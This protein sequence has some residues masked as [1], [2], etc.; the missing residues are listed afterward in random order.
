[1]LWDK[2]H[3]MP[4]FADLRCFDAVSNLHLNLNFTTP[5]DNGQLLE[6]V[7]FCYAAEGHPL[8]D[9][10]SFYTYQEVDN[11]LYIGWDNSFTD[12]TVVNMAINMALDKMWFLINKQPDH[13]K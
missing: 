1:M 9:A 12:E 10:S 8:S 6:W 5:R 11:V 4:R 13:W 7:K 3:S 2:N